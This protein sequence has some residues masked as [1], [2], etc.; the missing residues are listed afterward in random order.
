M[1]V[2]LI[3]KFDCGA[4]IRSASRGA[5]S[6]TAILKGNKDQYMLTTCEEPNKFVVVELCEEILVETVELANFEFFSSTVETFRVLVSNRYPP[7]TDWT[8]IGTFRAENNRLPQV[9]KSL[10][11]LIDDDVV[12]MDGL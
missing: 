12:V 1:I 9:L 10:L 2:H 7:K 5:S 3:F 4:V 8:L 11:Y 6:T